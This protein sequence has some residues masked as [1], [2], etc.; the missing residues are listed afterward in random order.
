[1]RRRTVRAAGRGITAGR[2][3]AWED[4]QARVTCARSGRRWLAH[5]EEGAAERESTRQARGAAAPERVAN[6]AAGDPDA[7]HRGFVATPAMGDTV[8][9]D[10]LVPAAVREVEGAPAA[11]DIL[12]GARSHRGAADPLVRPRD[13]R[14]SGAIAEGEG[15][16]L[17]TL[18]VDG[19]PTPRA[20][21]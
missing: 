21:G 6:A 1:M 13:A 20:R 5:S 16:V 14:R 10:G 15:E 9:R 7:G 17:V 19:G 18:V 3:A 4:R 2:R 11:A 8:D 12:R